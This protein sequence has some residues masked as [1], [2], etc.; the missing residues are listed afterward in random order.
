MAIMAL[1]R[2]TIWIIVGWFALAAAV[3]VVIR[4][5]TLKLLELTHHGVQA[6]AR[7]MLTDCQNHYAIYYS[8]VA[9]QKS[10]TDRATAEDCK[11]LNAGDKL[12]IYYSK[13]MPNISGYGDPNRQLSANLVVIGLIIALFPSWIIFLVVLRI[14]RFFEG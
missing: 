5:D 10:Y 4:L 13:R 6:S 8:Y 1:N 2:R 9:S 14:R 11:S 12:L 7:V 3:A